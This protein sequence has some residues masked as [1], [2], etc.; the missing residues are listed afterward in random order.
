M[1][2]CVRTLTHSLTH[3]LTC[4]HL[5]SLTLARVV[6]SP[7]RQ[8]M[9]RRSS[10]KRRPTEK[11][12]NTPIRPKR[13]RVS[14]DRTNP[15]KTNRDEDQ[16]AATITPPVV[17]TTRR[18]QNR[19]KRPTTK[20]LE[21]PDVHMCQCGLLNEDVTVVNT[22]HNGHADSCSLFNN[23]VPPASINIFQPTAN[24]FVSH[25]NN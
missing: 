1:C 22:S 16:S 20:Q 24:K 4:T 17:R 19:S 21:V 15:H 23:S 2:V 11:S 8:D 5:H 10:R 12:A 14:H 13:K 25:Q 18:R 7:G 9:A 6:W 3:S